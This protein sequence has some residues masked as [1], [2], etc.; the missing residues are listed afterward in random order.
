MNCPRCKHELTIAHNINWLNCDIYYYPVCANC[1]WTTKS[2]FDSKEEVKIHM[3][4]YYE[5]D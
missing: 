4:L 5:E 1:G 2:V 3:K